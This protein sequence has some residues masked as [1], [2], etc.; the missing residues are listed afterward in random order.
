MAWL[1]NVVVTEKK[2]SAQIGMN[3]DI[4]HANI[5]IQESHIPVPTVHTLRHKLNGS[6]VFT[7]LDLGHSFH[8]MLLGET[9]R[10]LTNFYT[11]EGIY[12]FKHLVMGAGPASQEFHEQLRQ[13]IVGIE[14]VIQIEDD[15]L[16]HGKGQDQHNSHLQK[17][18]NRLQER[19]ELR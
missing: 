9:S 12:R 19:L 14:G 11:H 17:V 18:L 7:K 5:A 1:F 2:T 15:L 3:I 10:R 8:Q 16:V 6:T 4:R 13:A